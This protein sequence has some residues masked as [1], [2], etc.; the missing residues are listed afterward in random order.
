MLTVLIADDHAIVRR[1]IIQIIKA[2][3]PSAKIKEAGDAETLVKYALKENF[4]IIISDMSMPGR[5]GMDALQQ[6]KSQNAQ[7]K[8]LILS[9]YP[10][11]QYAIRVLKSGAMGYL[12][13]DAAPEELIKAIQKILQ[14]RKYISSSIAEILATEIMTDSDKPNYETLSN[15]EFDVFKLLAFGKSVSDI[16]TL[17]S[18]SVTTI[19]TYRA[20]IMTKLQLKTN[21][22]L[23]KYAIENSLI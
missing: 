13:K 2:E 18:L 10:E 17:L 19:S 5:S 23:T 9:I 4:D 8:V 20:R 7:A 15:R 12:N 1:G 14:G 21:S 22:D 3:Y 6:I 16:A 11:E